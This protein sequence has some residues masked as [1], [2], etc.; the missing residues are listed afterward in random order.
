MAN[1]VFSIIINNVLEAAFFISIFANKI[2][3]GAIINPPPIPNKPVNTPITTPI[4]GNI[5]LKLYFFFFDFALNNIKEDSRITSE[6]NSINTLCFV[7]LKN[8]IYSG[9]AGNKKTLEIDVKNNAG[10][11]NNN[12]FRICKF[13]CAICLIVPKK[14]IKKTNNNEYVVAS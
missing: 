2:S 12:I 8:A 9:I 1:N 14:E 3:A 4:K 10:I 5:I 11:I 6:K 7:L 13:F